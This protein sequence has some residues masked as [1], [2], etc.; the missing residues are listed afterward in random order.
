MSYRQLPLSP[1]AGSARGEVQEDFS[2]LVSWRRHAIAAI[3]IAFGCVWVVNAWWAWQPAFRDNLIGYATKALYAQPQGGVVWLNAWL[4]V[5]S[6]NPRLFAFA[7]TAGE[8]G[9]AVGLL[10]GILSNLTCLGGV[11]LSLCLWSLASGSGY[12][13]AV[14]AT[15]S[16]IALLY[17]LFF[18]GLLLA[19]AGSFFGVDRYLAGTPEH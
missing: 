6:L 19:H 18:V 14:G 11:V 2:F 7:I 16:G 17:I 8:T 3:R 4:H 12:P 15:D 13:Y 1:L 5:I 9:I 10:L